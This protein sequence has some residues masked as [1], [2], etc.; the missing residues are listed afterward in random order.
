VLSV[1]ELREYERVLIG[2]EMGRVSCSRP[3]FIQC[4]FRNPICFFSNL[5]TVCRLHLALVRSRSSGKVGTYN[6]CL[7]RQRV[8]H[9]RPRLQR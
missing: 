3:D 2:M 8:R 6:E 5:R 1:R 4:R 9:S 7:H